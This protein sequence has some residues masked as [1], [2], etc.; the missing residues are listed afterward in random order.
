MCIRDR[1]MLLDNKGFFDCNNATLQ[2]FGYAKKEDFIKTHPGNVSPPYQPDGADSYTASGNN[3]IQAFKNGT[4]R[5]EWMYQRHNGEDFYADVL[6]TAFELNAKQ[7][8][9]ANVRDITQRKEAE[10]A[11]IK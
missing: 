6:L 7:V 8:L 5:F 4:N 10:K 2:M 9:Q 11:L 3:I 1:I